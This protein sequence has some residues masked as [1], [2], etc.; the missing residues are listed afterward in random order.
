MKRTLMQKGEIDKHNV[1]VWMDLFMVYY[2]LFVIKLL[3]FLDGVCACT[4][5]F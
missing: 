4:C 2:Y 3:L 1:F 5:L